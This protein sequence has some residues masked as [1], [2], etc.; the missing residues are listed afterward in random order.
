MKTFRTGDDRGQ[1]SL[2]PPSIEDYVGGGDLVR[3]V[4][5]FVDA[6]DLRRIEDKFSRLGRPAYSPKLLV[7]V[8]LYGKMRGIRTGRELS[9]ACGEN[10]RFMFLARNERPDFRTIND[11]RK[12]N[13][14]ELAGILMQTIE[15]GIRENLIDLR[16][17]C[18]DGTKI[19]ASAGRRSF[20]TPETL[21]QEL[22]VL[23]HEIKASLRADIEAEKEE[24]NQYGDDDG[25][26]TLPPEMQNKKVLADRI[27]AALAEHQACAREKP[28]AVSVT[29][30]E[31]RM[32]KGK[33]VNPSYNAQ[34]AIDAKSRLVVAGYAVNACCD[35][36]ELIPVVNEIERTTGAS[37]KRVVVDK[38]YTRCEHIVELE[39]RGIDGYVS[40]RQRRK[41]SFTYNPTKDSYTCPEG[42]ELSLIETRQT[43]KRYA[44]RGCASCPRANACIRKGAD[45]RVLQI[46]NSE[47]ALVRMEAKIATP[48]GKAMAVLRAS[49]IEPL[50]G[51]LKFAR[52]LRQMTIRGLKRVSWEW[53]F[54]LA[55]YNIEKLKLLTT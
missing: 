52:R 11:F 32:M 41:Q 38:G 29:D 53:Q 43:Q 20:K 18:I 30:P 13:A 9:R 14:E 22:A 10:L 3:Y 25:E 6:L 17:V 36:S 12:N 1:L 21:K 27:K 55:A 45:K 39:Q 26:G 47:A 42:K 33:G 35:S 44:R 51:F 16:Q 15:V 7:K 34:A 37:P 31:C 8:I 48:E 24:D 28:K 40:I 2:L 54:E 49:T 50:F 23:E 46:K 5:G 19:G 4:D